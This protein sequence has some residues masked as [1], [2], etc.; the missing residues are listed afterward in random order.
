MKMRIQ[1]FCDIVISHVQWYT[2]NGAVEELDISILKPKKSSKCEFFLYCTDPG[3]RR[4]QA[5]PKHKYLHNIQ[6][7]II[8]HKA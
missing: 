5:T 8:T 7:G 1:I 4:Q 6:H 3:N 2:I